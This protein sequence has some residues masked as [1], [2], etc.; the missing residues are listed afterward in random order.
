MSEQKS[1]QCPAC[2]ELNCFDHALRTR[3]DEVFLSE[4]PYKLPAGVTANTPVSQPS[5][6]ALEL[7]PCPFCGSVRIVAL[8]G[9]T[10]RW[11]LAECAECGARCGEV[12]AHD[13]YS[14]SNAELVKAW[15]VRAPSL[16]SIA[17]KARR[18]VDLFNEWLITD[19]EPTL[20]EGQAE[21]L[22]RIIAAEFGGGGNKWQ[23]GVDNPTTT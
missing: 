23:K 5:G 11:V 21:A 2:G 13:D 18:V 22:G 7:L 12:R 1:E 3:F 17:E 20:T 10:F 14:L 16:D 6:E 9:S 15:N 8:E 4:G 19:F